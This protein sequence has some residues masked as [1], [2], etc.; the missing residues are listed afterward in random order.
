[1]NDQRSSKH[2]GALVIPLVGGLLFIGGVKNIVDYV[3]WL[4]TAAGMSSVFGRP[5]AHFHLNPFPGRL[6]WDVIALGTI[7]ALG[8]LCMYWAIIGDRET[9]GKLATTALAV[10]LI[11]LTVIAGIAVHENWV[12]M[13][14]AHRS[15]DLAQGQWLDAPGFFWLLGSEVCCWIAYWWFDLAP[16][17]HGLTFPGPYTR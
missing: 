15:C 17:R 7:G 9:A 12:I 14:D 11:P 13:C 5:T 2:I 8:L 6:L 16:V 3:R 10:I 4:E 1:M